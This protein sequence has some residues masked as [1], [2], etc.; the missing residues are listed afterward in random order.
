MRQAWWARHA[1]RPDIVNRPRPAAG[2]E[3]GD[4]LLDGVPPGGICTRGG[5]CHAGVPCVAGVLSGV[6]RTLGLVVVE[7]GSRIAQV[8]RRPVPRGAP[9]CCRG[10]VHAAAPD[11]LLA[12]ARAEARARRAK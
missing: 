11:R 2:D 5:E 10:A 4:R 6:R 12:R 1:E 7:G 9:L 8:L 3:L